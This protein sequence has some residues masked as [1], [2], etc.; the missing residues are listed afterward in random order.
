MT[1]LPFMELDNSVEIRKG[2]EKLS[3]VFR[4]TKKTFGLRV[5]LSHP[6]KFNISLFFPS[7]NASWSKK[8]PLPLPINVVSLIPLEYSSYSTT[9]ARG[10]P[11][12]FSSQQKKPVKGTSNTYKMTTLL[13]KQAGL[14]IIGLWISA[15]VQ[16]W[17][18]LSI[19]MTLLWQGT[20]NHAV[21]LYETRGTK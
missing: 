17:K 20:E 2:K 21:S 6:L 11:T 15:M 10:F 3:N 16:N 14:R 19:I 4:K 5:I 12:S 18:I 13:L 7:S 9:T 8:K 1:L